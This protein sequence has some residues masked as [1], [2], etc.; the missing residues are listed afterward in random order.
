MQLDTDFFAITG[1]PD[2]G[3]QAVDVLSEELEQ[4]SACNK[5]EQNSFPGA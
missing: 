3:L 4:L 5:Q 2:F 1:E